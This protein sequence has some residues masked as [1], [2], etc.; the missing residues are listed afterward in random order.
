MVKCHLCIS[1]PSKRLWGCTW[2]VATCQ[3][4]CDWSVACWDSRGLPRRFGG[5]RIWYWCRVK[6]QR[7]TTERQR[8]GLPHQRHRPHLGESILKNCRLAVAITTLYC[9]FFAVHIFPPRSFI[10]LE[11]PYITRQRVTFGPCSGTPHKSLII[12]LHPAHHV[13]TYCAS[14]IPLFLHMT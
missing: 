5:R 11:T 14:L 6:G 10:Y 12:S 3:Q 2:G 7:Q 13:F 9:S 4:Y 1:S 8:N